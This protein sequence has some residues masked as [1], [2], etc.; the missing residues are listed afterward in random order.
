M[1][2]ESYVLA[3]SLARLGIEHQRCYAAIADLLAEGRAPMLAMH[4]LSQWVDRLGYELAC[5]RVAL[6]ALIHA[7]H[8]PVEPPARH[9]PALRSRRYGPGELGQA[10][11]AI[12]GGAEDVS[13]RDLLQALK[14]GTSMASLRTCL[15]NLVRAG[16]VVWVRKGVYRLATRQSHLSVVQQ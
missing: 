14:P 11:L 7:Q 2:I 13:L 1:L 12:L 5:G 3:Q 8:H 10:V 9:A 16:Q 15:T 6:E 4:A